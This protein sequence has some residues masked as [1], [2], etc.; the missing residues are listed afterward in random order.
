MSLHLASPDPNSTACGTASAST[1]SSMI[2]S[3]SHTTS[4]TPASQTP[5]PTP[6]RPSFAPEAQN[7][8]LVL[9]PADLVVPTSSTSSISTKT[10]SASRS[11]LDF[12]VTLAGPSPST[13]PSN[14]SV[15]LA[16]VI[17]IAFVSSLIIIGPI[18]LACSGI[19][20]V[21]SLPIPPEMDTSSSSASSTI[22]AE[23]N[24]NSFSS[25]STIVVT[26]ASGPAV[27]S[28]TAPQTVGY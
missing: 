20:A 14:S 27:S 19:F 25:S 22:A 10:M 4:F 21:S 6:G 12:N 5:R 26:G 11:A 2:T 13:T 15:Y 17:I 3:A 18:A 1:G 9:Q 8:R 7:V 16:M 24:A 28:T 23:T